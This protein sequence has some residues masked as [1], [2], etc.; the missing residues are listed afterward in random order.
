[1]G[2]AFPGQP[3]SF[4]YQRRPV[5]DY[6]P[7]PGEWRKT[8]EQRAE[9]FMAKWIVAEKT[10]ARLRHA[11]LCPNVT[12]RTNERIA[13]IKRVRAGSLAIVN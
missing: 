8:A 6:S 5:D 7:A 9:H 3:Q 2:E 11:V 1:M 10:K 12:G 13:Q 4:R